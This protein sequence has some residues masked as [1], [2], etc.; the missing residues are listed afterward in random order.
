MIIFFISLICVKTY[1]AAGINGKTPVSITPGLYRE[2]DVLC[3]KKPYKVSDI[4]VG[5]TFKIALSGFT[6]QTLTNGMQREFYLTF[7]SVTEG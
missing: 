4:A 7:S 2:K 1:D 3:D 5:D 6:V